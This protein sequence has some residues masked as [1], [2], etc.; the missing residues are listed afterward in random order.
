MNVSTP[1]KF[2]GAIRHCARVGFIVA[3]WLGNRRL[4]PALAIL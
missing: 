3:S 2:P 1:G 4:R